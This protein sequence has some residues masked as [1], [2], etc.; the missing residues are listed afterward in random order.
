MDTP[1]L[2]DLSALM[3]PEIRLAYKRKFFKEKNSWSL[4]LEYRADFLMH[5]REKW[6]RKETVCVKDH[7]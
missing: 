5:T 7:G 2:V 6:A 1:E 3:R 4:G